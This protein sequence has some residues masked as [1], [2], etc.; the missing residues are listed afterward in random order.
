MAFDTAR[1]EAVLFGGLGQTGG[2]DDTWVLPSLGG[3]ALDD[4]FND[5][6]INASLWML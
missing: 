1:A 3:P 6:S 2:T 5:N 4:N